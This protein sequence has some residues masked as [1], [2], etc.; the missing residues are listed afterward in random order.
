MKFRSAKQ[1]LGWAAARR[2]PALTQLK[3]DERVQERSSVEDDWVASAVFSAL[4]RA[5]VDPHGEQADEVIA[6][7]TR[8]DHDVDDEGRSWSTHPADMAAEGLARSLEDDA[9]A[10]A[11][12]E[13]LRREAA[14]SATT[15]ASVVR[16]LE[17]EL[18]ELGLL[19]RRVERPATMPWYALVDGEVMK[20]TRVVDESRLS[21]EVLGEQAELAELA[22]LPVFGP[23]APPH[24]LARAR[25]I[26]EP[27]GRDLAAGVVRGEI[28]SFAEL[29]RA[30]AKFAS[31]SERTAR[32]T[33]LGVWGVRGRRGRPAKKGLAGRKLA[34]QGVVATDSCA[35]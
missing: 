4:A 9:D 35:L 15:V 10:S 1:A 29:D 7:A 33:R 5:G 24:D 17:V 6:W 28:G 27:I 18:L 13:A 2:R 14:A 21:E 34:S 26:F 31:V 32:S 16:A 8:S 12:V 22:E 23:V 3:A 20:T 30:V 11:Q 19:E 25:V